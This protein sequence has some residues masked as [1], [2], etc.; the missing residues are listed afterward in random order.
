MMIPSTVLQDAIALLTV[1][2]NT[3]EPSELEELVAEFQ[4]KDRSDQLLIAVVALCR[5][6][7]LATSKMI[8]VVDDA[9][10]DHQANALTEDELLPVAMDVIRQYAHAAARNAAPAS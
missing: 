1:A 2:M 3:D 7:C 6:L 5:S 4:A 10:S 9:L 8:H